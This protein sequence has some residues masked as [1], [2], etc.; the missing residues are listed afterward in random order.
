MASCAA[1]GYRRRSELGKKEK[2]KRGQT[3]FPGWEERW[4]MRLTP[5]PQVTTV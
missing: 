4:K 1:V 5:F 2:E 3:H